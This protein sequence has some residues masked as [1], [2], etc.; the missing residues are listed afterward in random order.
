MRKRIS[1][2]WVKIRKIYKNLR[3]N[4][5]SG[6]PAHS[7]TVRLATTLPWTSERYGQRDL[8]RCLARNLIHIFM[9]FII[10]FTNVLS[11]VLLFSKCFFLAFI[12]VGITILLVIWN[13]LPISFIDMIFLHLWILKNVSVWLL[14]K[15]LKHPSIQY[16]IFPL[17]LKVILQKPHLYIHMQI[18]YESVIKYWNANYALHT[19]N[20]TLIISSLAT[21]DCV[22]HL[23]RLI[24]LLFHFKFK[25]FFQN[26]SP[27]YRFRIKQLSKRVSVSFSFSFC[28]V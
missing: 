7:G 17:T 21:V 2:V 4:E 10:M 18:V 16:G 26:S 15:I 3:K 27:V 22:H 8:G 5:E 6:T 13:I 14:S 1:K 20:S 9:Q 24:S 19:E 23:C 28:F 25:R 12:W 11:V